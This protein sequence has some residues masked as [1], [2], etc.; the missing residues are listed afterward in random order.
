MNL[1]VTFQAN[2]SSTCCSE[3]PK[4]N[5][6]SVCFCKSTVQHQSEEVTFTKS[7]QNNQTIV[8]KNTNVKRIAV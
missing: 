5:D 3:L 8:K 4:Y 7:I 2:M 1:K 6:L